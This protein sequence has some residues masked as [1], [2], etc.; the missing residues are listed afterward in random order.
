[1]FLKEHRR[2]FKIKCYGLEDRIR[3]Q[4]IGPISHPLHPLVKLPI[5]GGS[6]IFY[7]NNYYHLDS[8]KRQLNTVNRLSPHLLNDIYKRD[9]M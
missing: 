5:N 4:H 6:K 3:N 7:L 2:Q 1:M 9:E 8:I